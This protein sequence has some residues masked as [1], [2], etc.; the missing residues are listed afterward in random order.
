VTP[1]QAAV[2]RQHYRLGS[3]RQVQGLTVFLLL[4]R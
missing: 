4:R 2:L 3:I 1:A